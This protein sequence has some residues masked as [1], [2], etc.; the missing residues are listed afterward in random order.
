[1]ALLVRRGSGGGRRRATGLG[2]LA[3]GLSRRHDG[4]GR[5]VVDGGY[6]SR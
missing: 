6:V 4:D 1:M 3:S 2:G 5:G